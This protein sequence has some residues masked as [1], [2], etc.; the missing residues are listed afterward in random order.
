M[1]RMP[2]SAVAADAEACHMMARLMFALHMARI[3]WT[4]AWCAWPELE[5]TTRALVR[6]QIRREKRELERRFGRAPLRV[7]DGGRGNS[8]FNGTA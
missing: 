8:N 4:S 2:E 5:R 3:A 6:L 1:W 7:I